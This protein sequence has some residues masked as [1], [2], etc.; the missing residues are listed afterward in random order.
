MCVRTSMYDGRSTCKWLLRST[1]IRQVD[2]PEGYATLL[3]TVVLFLGKDTKR[4]RRARRARQSQRVLY[5]LFPI[6]TAPPLPPSGALYVPRPAGPPAV[7]CLRSL[8]TSGRLYLLLVLGARR[9][10]LQGL[11]ETGN[12]G[13]T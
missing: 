11:K 12:P 7:C 4:K 10:T 5:S 13:A 3:S 2:L 6:A 9:K 1:V 8:P